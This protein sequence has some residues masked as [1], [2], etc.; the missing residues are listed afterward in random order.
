MGFLKGTSVCRVLIYIY[1]YIFVLMLYVI[2]K[3]A[4]RMHVCFMVQ[5]GH[6]YRSVQFGYVTQV[7]RLC[8]PSNNMVKSQYLVILPRGVTSSLN[9]IFQY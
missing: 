4:R 8:Y 3:K 7:I 6:V 2:F 9:F 1:I 5:L